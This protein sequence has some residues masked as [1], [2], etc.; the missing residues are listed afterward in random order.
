MSL[1]TVAPLPDD[2]RT[3]IGI[4]AHAHAVGAAV[5]DVEEACRLAAVGLEVGCAARVL[6]LGRRRE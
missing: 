6:L 5:I 1:R 2:P 4:V 3:D